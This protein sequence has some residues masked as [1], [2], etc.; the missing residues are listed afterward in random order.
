MGLL[1]GLSDMG[2]GKL[3]DAEIF[4]EE[5]KPVPKR[6]EPVKK[7]ETPFDENDV[8]FDKKAECPVCGKAFTN[9]TV[10]TGKARPTGQDQDLRP[11]Y[12]KFDPLKYDVVVCPYCGYA[13][14]NNYFAPL[15][16]AQVKLLREGIVGKVHGVASN[17]IISYD[18]AIQRYQL[19]LASSIVKRGKDSEK[20]LVC[21]KRGWVIRGKRETLPADAPDYDEVMEE[22]LKDENEALQTAYDGFINARQKESYPIG[23]MDEPTLDYLIAVL[24][25]RFG[26]Y[27][28]AQKMI[29]SILISKTANSRIKD[30][31]R[32]L[33]DVV[34]AGM[35]A[36]GDN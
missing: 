11:R 6:V 4:K 16:S 34:L 25:A 7:E 24:S 13:V 12:A 36:K 14:L 35:K 5:K 33:K 27:D 21:L 19:A 9:R 30:R 20:A 23:G 22:T 29:S 17:P 8:L 32:D 10:F 18:D 31:A 26:K 2:L 3:E 28:V 15:P 1:S